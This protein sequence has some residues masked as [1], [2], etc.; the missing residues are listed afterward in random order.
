MS[1]YIMLC[2]IMLYY[3][4]LCYNMLYYVMST[5]Q[6]VY[7]KIT[8]FFQQVEL[9]KSELTCPIE[10]EELFFMKIFCKIKERAPLLALIAK[11]SL[12]TIHVLTYSCG[13]VI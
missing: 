1:C 10:I 11:T 6:T 2:Y 8:K 12:N 4:I 13:L 5:M 3:V 7:S 9:L